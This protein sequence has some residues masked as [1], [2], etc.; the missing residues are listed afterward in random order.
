MDNID[1]CGYDFYNLLKD[2]HAHVSAARQTETDAQEVARLGQQADEETWHVVTRAKQQTRNR[3][4][5]LSGEDQHNR[6][7]HD[8]RHAQ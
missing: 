1:T 6:G 4:S 5:T 8:E 3:A 2:R 7:A